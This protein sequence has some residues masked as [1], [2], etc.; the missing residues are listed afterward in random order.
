MLPYLIKYWQ[1]TH[2]GVYRTE[3]PIGRTVGRAVGRALGKALGKALGPGRA[4]GKVLHLTKSLWKLEF[5]I[6]D[7]VYCRSNRG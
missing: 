3:S 6:L 2:R 7:Q 1:G 5:Q 4:V